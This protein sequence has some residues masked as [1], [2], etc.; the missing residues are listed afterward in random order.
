MWRAQQMSKLMGSATTRLLLIGATFVSGLLAG[1]NIDRAFVAMPAWQQLGA[2][3]WA[4]FSRHADLGNG[5]WLYPIEAIGGAFL[6]LAAAASYY[7]DRIGRLDVSIPLLVA[8][9][10]SWG[11]LLSTVKAAPIVLNIG[12]IT[13]PVALQTAFEDFRFWGNIR[14]AFQ[15]FEFAALAGAL[16]M[17]SRMSKRSSSRPLNVNEPQDVSD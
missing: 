14:G 15:V 8:I 13:D 11:G 9:V 3:S 1:G 16:G 6:T 12:E 17:L 10:S 7:F 2:S 5:L 4:E